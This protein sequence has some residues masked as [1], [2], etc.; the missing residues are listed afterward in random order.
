MRTLKKMLAASVA[1]ATMFSVTA[2]ASFK[3][4]NAINSDLIS[5][6]ELLTALKIIQGDTQGN[7]NPEKGITRA[8]A[9]KMIYVLKMKGND[10]GAK[11]WS[12]TSVFSDTKWHWAEGYINYSANVGILDGVGNGRFNPEGQ[13]TGAELAKMLLVLAGYKTDYTGFGWQQAVISDGVNAGIFDEYDINYSAAAP[14]QWAAKLFTNTINVVRKPIYIMGDI[15]GYGDTYGQ[16]SLEM[17][18]KE[19]IV[20]ATRDIALD[21]TPANN[22][23]GDNKYSA[24]K[25]EGETFLLDYDI[26]DSLLGQKV[27]FI[28]KGD[29]STSG[30]NTVKVYGV[31]AVK[32]T[33]AEVAFDQ[34]TG[35]T[36]SGKYEMT[37]D[38]VKYTYPNADETLTT[39]V[40]YAPAAALKVSQLSNVLSSNMVKLVDTDGDGL[41]DTALITETSYAKVSQ[42][43]ADKNTFKTTDGTAFDADVLNNEDEF[44][45]YSF[46]DTIAKDDIVAITPDFSSGSERFDVSL[47]DT[48]EGEVSSFTTGSDGNIN[49]VTIDG[50]KY[51]FATENLFPSGIYTDA[52][53]SHQYYFTDGK[54]IVFSKGELNASAQDQ[55]N[56]ALVVDVAK[57]Q[58]TDTFGNP[59]ADSYTLKVQ[60]V[61]NDGKNEIL[62]YNVPATTTGSVIGSNAN[63]GGDNYDAVNAKKGKLVE[64]VMKDGK[65]Y[66]KELAS[67]ATGDITVKNATGV[68][69]Y[70]PSTGRVTDVTMS[71]S[72]VQDTHATYLTDEN[73]YFFVQSKDSDGETIYSVVKASE[74]KGITTGTVTG[75][76]LG[77][78]KGMPVLRYG[79]LVIDGVIPGQSVQGNM[80]LGTGDYTISRDN[81]NDRWVVSYKVSDMDGTEKTLTMHGSFSDY[82]A[83]SNVTTRM[84]S[85]NGKLIEYTETDGIVNLQDGVK[86]GLSGFNKGTLTGYSGGTAF[87]GSFYTV[88]N[89]TKIFYVDV[90]QTAT[91]GEKATMT[92]GSGLP[93]A[94][95]YDEVDDDEIVTKQYENN[96][97]YKLVEGTTRID[98]IIVEIDGETLDGPNSIF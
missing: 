23:D 31:S 43:N 86:L 17:V 82:S 77:V 10:D 45:Q 25:V 2:F 74:L 16:S 6:V 53:T 93:L 62:E 26:P 70:T 81:D 34:I 15:V 57:V 85:F 29:P 96:V 88:D 98:T 20:T 36:V 7:F 64:F 67:V 87:I 3:D 27:T 92:S 39:Y 21:A 68:L 84:N 73:S 28:T 12:G 97:Y 14:R 60:I 90:D 69:R 24:V 41:F 5:D 71:G 63:N 49:S 42:F 79:H 59:I 65:V 19:G 56:L 32:S 51:T 50:V 11:G 8:E 48:L 47:A 46:N 72:S 37:V 94:G 66:F 1:A 75:A 33:V 30:S 95:T 9:A 35:K 38:G 55:S 4:E 40:N 89:D 76:Q 80:A 52:M 22:E 58:N 18:T 78:T 91:D 54:H 44:A 13:V 61:K 83:L